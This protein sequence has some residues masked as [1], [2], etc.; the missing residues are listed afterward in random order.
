MR[1]FLFLLLIVILSACRPA[2][3]TSTIVPATAAATETAAPTRTPQPSPT[4]SPTSIPPSP[5]ATEIPFAVC[6]PLEDETI[7]SLPLILVNPLVEPYAWGTDFGHPGLDFAY[8]QRDDRLSIEGIEIYAIL[9]GQVA[10]T[11]EDNYPY[12]YAVVIET[13]LSS[14]PE[15]MQQSLMADYDPVPEDLEYQYNCPDV[16]TPTVTGDY[17]LYTLYAHLG[18]PPEF[19]KGDGVTCGQL[20]G[21]VGNSG[22]SS[23]PHLHLETRL[24]PAGLEIPTMAHYQSNASI[25]QLGNY[26]LW[27]SSGYYQIVDPY[28]ILDSTP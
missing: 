10:L 16:P 21:Q 25:E 3:V 22:W 8:F 7:D 5:T 14:L 24:G 26:C 23:N 12:G 11:L 6:S 9:S 27:R 28:E 18:S 13:P 4:P 1:K 17:S 2:R 15:G 20:L 19:A